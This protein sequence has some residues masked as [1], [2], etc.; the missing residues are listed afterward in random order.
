MGLGF[1]T[2]RS[3]FTTWVGGPTG[4][5]VFCRHSSRYIILASFFM[6]SYG[7]EVRV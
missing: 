6:Y 7:I 5:S 2:Q 3:S 1:R 4:G